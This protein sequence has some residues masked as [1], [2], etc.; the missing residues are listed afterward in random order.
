M[1]TTVLLKL[2]DAADQQDDPDY[3]PV[4]GSDCSYDTP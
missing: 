2:T 4:S 1:G 3:P